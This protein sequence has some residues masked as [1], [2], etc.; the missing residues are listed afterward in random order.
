MIWL[1][2]AP[3]DD[4]IVVSDIGEQWSPQTE[5]ARHADIPITPIS[6]PTGNMPSTI[7]IRIPNVPHEVPVAKEIPIATRNMIAGKKFCKVPALARALST[8][9]SEPR[10]PVTFLSAVASVRMRIAGTIALKPLG[11]HSIASLKVTVLL[12]SI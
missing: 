8:N 12:Q 6:L 5:P 1:H 10:S 3:A 7:G 9:A 11:I 2:S 4:I